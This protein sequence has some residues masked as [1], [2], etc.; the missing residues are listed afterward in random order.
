MSCR[1]RLAHQTPKS[2]SLRQPRFVIVGVPEQSRS[3]TLLIN[4]P[5]LLKNK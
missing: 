3:I 5:E 1:D 2:R 4:W